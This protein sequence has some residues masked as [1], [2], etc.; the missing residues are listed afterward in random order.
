M[1]FAQKLQQLRREKG[2]S[3]EE[4]ANAFDVTRQAVSKWESGQAYPETEK[5]LLISDYFGVSLDTLLRPERTQS[6]ADPAEAPQAKPP[7]TPGEESPPNAE[8]EETVTHTPPPQDTPKQP[9]LQGSTPSVSM[10]EENVRGFLSEKGQQG[11]VIAGGVGILIASLCPLLWFGGRW[12]VTLFLLCI[13]VGVAVLVYTH[14]LPRQYQWMKRHPAPIHPLLLED[15]RRYA[16]VQRR[17]YGKYIAL[18][19]LLV[20]GGVVALVGSFAFPRFLRG[21]IRGL[22]PVCWGAGVA[23]FIYAGVNSSALNTISKG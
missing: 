16:E 4:L 7:V 12:G 19:V 14:S 21:T 18:G 17:H 9:T 8:Q 13:A 6:N 22:A 3:Q 1:D 5:L 20:L 11:Q 2:V 15:F 10:T 23:L